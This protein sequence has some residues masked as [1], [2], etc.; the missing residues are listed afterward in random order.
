MRLTP[1]ILRTWHSLAGLN[2]A[3]HGIHS[4]CIFSIAEN[5][6]MS[7][8]GKAF[9]CAEAE[10]WRRE[11]HADRRKVWVNDYGTGR[12]GLRRISKIAESAAVSP[13]HGRLLSFFSGR[14][15]E[16]PVIELGMS[17]GI[18]TMY[19]ALANRNT[20]VI[21]VEGSPA[22]ICTASK[23]FHK[24]GADNVKILSGDFD[25]HIENLTVNYPSP[26]LIF[27]DGNHRGCALIHYFNAFAA[28][29]G[30]ETVLLA[31]D[32]DYSLGMAKAWNKIKKDARVSESIDLG[33]M[34]VLFFRIRRNS[35]HYRIRY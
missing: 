1:V 35:C 15:G 26:G 7:R 19:M 14:S 22:L 6:A 32:I 4:P 30:N 13:K 18:S 31:H 23:G 11:L 24:Y 33:S 5:I 8:S 17:L 29:A 3:G 34:G 20:A 9:H 2:T 16:K 10:A 12:H 25:S 28:V 27:I 21:T